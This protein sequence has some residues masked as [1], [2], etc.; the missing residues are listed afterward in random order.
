M[1]RHWEF[2]G[3]GVELLWSYGVSIGVRG[4]VRQGGGAVAIDLPLII[5]VI[6]RQPKR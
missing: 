4:G 3:W 1:I 2:Y 6:Y 5:V